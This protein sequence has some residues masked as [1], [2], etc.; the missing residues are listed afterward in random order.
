[1]EHDEVPND[2]VERPVGERE[3]FHVATSKVDRR[4]TPARE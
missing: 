3:R 1:M 2:R 4:M